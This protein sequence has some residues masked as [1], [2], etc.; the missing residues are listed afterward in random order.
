MSENK[1]DLLENLI[2]LIDEGLELAKGNLVEGGSGCGRAICGSKL[3]FI[4]DNMQE[5][6]RKK[7]QKR[8]EYVSKAVGKR[9]LDL[10]NEN[11]YSVNHL[12]ELSGITQST[13]SD[14]VTG[15]SKNIGIIT[16]TKL[17]EGLCITLEEFFTDPL[18]EKFM[19]Y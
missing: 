9:I 12:S 5:Q 18:F 19:P 8:I 6:K 2:E 11:G 7:E 16:I 1:D 14:I 10:C 3:D 17:C 13:V 4:K 15:K